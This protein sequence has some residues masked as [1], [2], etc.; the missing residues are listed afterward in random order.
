MKKYKGIWNRENKIKKLKLT[1]LIEFYN[2]LEI[3]WNLRKDFIINM[4]NKVQIDL[5]LYNN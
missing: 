4:I 5:I 3:G 1:K 2:L